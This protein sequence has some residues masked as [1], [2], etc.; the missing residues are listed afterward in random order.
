[1]IIVLTEKRARHLAENFP[2]MAWNLIWPDAYPVCPVCGRNDMHDGYREQ[3]PE[4]FWVCW[5]MDLTDEFDLQHR[6]FPLVSV[7]DA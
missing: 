1:M 7:S 6:A 2:V 3:G 5:R 4:R